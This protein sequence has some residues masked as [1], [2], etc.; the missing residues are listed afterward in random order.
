MGRIAADRTFYAYL[1][2]VL[3]EE[4]G[5]Q[6][7]FIAMTWQIFV[8]THDPF[9]LGLIGL[10]MF[11]PALLLVAFSGT[12]AD[13]FD[14]RNVIVASRAVELACCAAFFALVASG[15][16]LVWLYFLVF[17]VLGSVR[18]L[19][20][21][22]EK[23]LLA[24]IVVGERYVNAQATYASGREIVVIVG[25]A[26]GGLLLAVSAHV[27]VFAGALMIVSSIVAYLFVRIARD[28][29]PIVPVSLKNAFA[30]L[31]FIK[32]RPVIFGAISLDLFAVLFGGATALMP[33]YADT[34]LHVGPV[35]LGYL[36]SAPSVGAALV[37]VYLARRSPRNR[38]GMLAFLAAVGFGMATIAFGLSK[39]LWL[40][41]VAL[42]V[43]GAFDVV[44]G[45]VR[46]GL[47]QLNT[48]NEM[49][50]RV[51]AIQSVFTTASNELGAFESGTL[52]ALIGTVPA[53]V[54]GGAASLLVAAVC[55]YVFPALRTADGFTESGRV[56]VAV[57]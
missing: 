44:G 17:F 10:A 29:H 20:R 36:R 57:G 21:P 31:S 34:I 4:T 45:V 5:I 27:A 33:V 16:S 41:V 24:N 14:R 37:A 39:V 8:L 28:E 35:G 18:A 7:I 40:S 53:V 49:R 38:I 47:I 50:G 22:A 43:M 42:I 1:A 55:A 11:L 46:N 13:R 32:T 12:I 56:D 52:A 25:P 9:D 48:P 6:I 3:C 54:A 15:T 51:T 2:G 30:G 26:T 23:A 19:S